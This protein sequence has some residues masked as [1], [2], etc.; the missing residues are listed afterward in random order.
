MYSTTSCFHAF[1][2]PADHITLPE[3][4]TFPFFYQPHEIAV[5]AAKEVMNQLEH[6]GDS[7]QVSYPPQVNSASNTSQQH[8][9][10]FEAKQ[11]SGKMFG[12]LVVK[13][14]SG[15][16]GYLKAFSGKI[17]D[18]NHHQG[19]VP[20]V[21]D[22]LK[23]DGYFRSEMERINTV[24]SDLKVAQSDIAIPELSQQLQ[25][26]QQ[27]AQQEVETLRLETVKRRA[28]RKSRREEANQLPTV[29]R[30]KELEILGTK[31]V[32]DK[33]QLKHLKNHWQSQ[34]ESVQQLLD[35]KLNEVERLKQLRAN[36][37]HQLQHKLFKS[38]RFL[39]ANRESKD[40]IEIFAN[41]TSPIPPAGSGEC[42]APKLL[43][44]AY[45]NQLQPIAL[46]E[47]WWGGSPK[48]EIR[49]HKQYYPACQSK[50]Q[51]ILGHM[52]QGLNVDENPL[53]INPA[54][55][56]PLELLYQ[57]DAIVVINKPAN[58]L[59]VPG[60]HIKDSALTRLEADFP[61]CEGPFVI[62]RLDMATS[63]ILVFALTRRANKSL[64]KQFIS[65][66]VKKR[67]VA[68]LARKDIAATGKIDLPMRGDPYDRPRQLVC[69][70]H[71][72]SALTTWQVKTQDESGTTLYLHPH[73]GRTHQLRVHCAH[74]EGLDSPIIGDTLYG[75][76]EKRL[77]LHAE[78]LCFK[79]PYTN[80][81]LQFQVDAEF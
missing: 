58:F 14:A 65:R 48:S 21:F 72:K 69:H 11:G 18:N 46:A 5:M 77:Y 56:K 53:L 30:E 52:L 61:D 47:F 81:T 73:T 7:F 76:P 64:Q 26:L 37:S 32:A 71:G 80:E 15:Q 78:S 54:Q 44:Y 50:C 27:Q 6:I 20:P 35:A 16:L 34:I 57:D 22:M 12:V 59:S 3:R 63:G 19:F 29:E 75:E 62:H 10:T 79:H 60:R 4:F 13:D 24:G 45:A 1:N 49:K 43:Q 40:L 66:S 36:L 70:E 51:P 74:H 67:Y 2:Q 33:N 55:D 42:A 8:D 31:S 17:N 68:K 25:Q 28:D 41:T 9:H 23:N 38:Y 39:N